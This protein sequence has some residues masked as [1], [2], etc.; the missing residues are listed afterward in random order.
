MTAMAT[1][2]FLS[3]FPPVATEAWE[4]A[5]R[6]DL[7]GTA[8]TEKLIWHS[9]EGFDVKPYYRAEDLAGIES[10]HA[11]PGN[12]P[13]SRGVRSR[14]GWRI[15]EEVDAVDS[16]DANRVAQLAVAAGAEEIAFSRVVVAN[17][18]DLAILLYNLSEVAVHFETASDATV[19]HLID[20]LHN[21]P[22]ALKLS[23][24]LDWSADPDVSASI[25]AK[26]PSSL[27]PFTIH[28]DTFQEGGATSVEEVGFALASGVDF[29]RE[30]QQRGLSP[31][32]AAAS[33]TF[34]FAMGPEFF[35]QAAK[36]RAFRLAWAQ[37]AESFGIA[38]ESMRA[39]IY[40]RTSRWN[41]NV[42]D[43]HT[44]AL[45]GT[46]EAI[47]AI[48]GGADSIYVA[49]FDECCGTLDE[50]SRR[51]ARNTQ[52][53]LKQEAFLARVADPGCGSYYVE[54]L[55]DS[56]AA[57]AWKLLQEIESA[58]GWRTAAEMITRRLELR[59]AEQQEK[60]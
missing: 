29:L 8:H 23:A 27:A 16:E 48:L 60:V 19:G 10:L 47:S 11:A 49:P 12:F 5:I 6:E 52:I 40:A 14:G 7:K 36:L 33:I 18:S 24:G 28:A 20:R 45:R 3:E 56:I 13:H 58:G 4:Q 43:P 34:S 39:R 9:P 22:G 17:S 50:A 1:P 44:N 25:L 37:A 46:T 38:R 54:T 42:S 55:T 35:M 59:S 51:L 26:T 21:R 30:I 32:R 53:I 41:R 31:E 57:G 15:R 2:F